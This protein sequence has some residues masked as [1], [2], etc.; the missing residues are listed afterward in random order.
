MI[1]PI[2]QKIT[3][4]DFTWCLHCERAFLT[5]TA[6]QITVKGE[7]LQ[8]CHYPDCDGTLID[9]WSWSDVRKDKNG[10]ERYP[11]IPEIGKVYPLYPDQT[12]PGTK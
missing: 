2:A 4:N 12:A 7:E 8:L 1:M 11:A 10:L 9:F 3:E 6:R 5:E